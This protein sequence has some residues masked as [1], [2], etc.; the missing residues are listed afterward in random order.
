[1]SIDKIIK[2]FD[3][4]DLIDPDAKLE[5]LEFEEDVEDPDIDDPDDDDDFDKRWYPD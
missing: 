1:M 2:K 5:D 3:E 4:D